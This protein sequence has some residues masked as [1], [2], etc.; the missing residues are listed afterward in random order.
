MKN[1]HGN[2]PL[3]YAASKGHLEVVQTLVVATGIQ[4]MVKNRYDRTPLDG[5]NWNQHPKCL[6][7]LYNAVHKKKGD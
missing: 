4:I 1:Q 5:A 2:T 3:Y 7:V 6:D